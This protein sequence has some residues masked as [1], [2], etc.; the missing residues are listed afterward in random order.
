MKNEMRLVIASKP[1]SKMNP[2]KKGVDT[3][4]LSEIVRWKV[5]V[6]PIQRP[7][8]ESACIPRRRI[9]ECQ[10]GRYGRPRFESLFSKRAD[11]FMLRIL[12]GI[13]QCFDQRRNDKFG[14]DGQCDQ[15]SCSSIAKRCIGIAQGGDNGGYRERSIC[16]Q[17]INRLMDVIPDLL[18]SICECRKQ[19]RPGGRA[20]VS[21]RKCRVKAREII[22]TTKHS[23]KFRN[24]IRCSCSQNP[25]TETRYDL[26]AQWP[27][28][29]FI[30]PPYFRNNR[31]DFSMQ[32]EFPLW[33]GVVKPIQQPWNCV[34]ADLPN[35]ARDVFGFSSEPG[36]ICEFVCFQK[37]TQRTPPNF[38]LAV[39]IEKKEETDCDQQTENEHSLFLLSHARTLR[40]SRNRCKETV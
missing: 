36:G 11:Y 31:I 10:Q 37:R 27:I 15:S 28:V 34:C 24:G 39:S 23:P 19:V 9:T 12:V 22:A 33:R 8:S 1:T 3:L 26:P 40:R 5:W 29:P 21:Q 38:R 13:A 16:S 25:E 14:F 2:E 18:V 6:D 35:L 30:I 17:A 32:G 4:L 7:F 20:D